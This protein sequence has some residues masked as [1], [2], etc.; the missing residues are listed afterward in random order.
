MTIKDANTGKAFDLSEMQS[1][2]DDIS[3]ALKK[4]SLSPPLT[5]SPEL[6]N[7]PRLGSLES[8][9]PSIEEQIR[10]SMDSDISNY[11]SQ[12]SS[13]VSNVDTAAST[14]PSARGK[15][16]SPTELV[17]D[18]VPTRL[19]YDRGNHLVGTNFDFAIVPENSS[20]SDT[21]HST[22]GSDE[23]QGV[24]LT[25][26][27]WMEQS[28]ST[29]P[30][31]EANAS[32]VEKPLTAPEINISDGTNAE[33]MLAAAEVLGSNQVAKES[34]RGK[35]LRR[36]ARGIKVATTHRKII[37][38]R[39]NAA[40]VGVR[41][42]VE[43]EITTLLNIISK[44]RRDNDALALQSNKNYIEWQQLDN[45]LKDYNYSLEHEDP[46]TVAEANN[47]MKQLQDKYQLLEETNKQQTMTL[48][49]EFDDYVHS[50]QGEVDAVQTRLH[51]AQEEIT[52][53]E[54]CKDDYKQQ[55]DNALSRQ[56]LNL[57]DQQ[58]ISAFQS[59]EMILIQDKENMSQLLEGETRKLQEVELAVA[60]LRLSRRD[61]ERKLEDAQD[62]ITRLISANELLEARAEPIDFLGLPSEQ[63]YEM[64]QKDQKL[65]EMTDELR[66]ANETIADIANANGDDTTAALMDSH[67]HKVNM[68][69]L[70][71]QT[72][73]HEISELQQKLSDQRNSHE[74]DQYYAVHMEEDMQELQI[75][76]NAVSKDLRA[77]REQ[78]ANGNHTLADPKSWQ[79]MNE[80]SE[81]REQAILLQKKAEEQLEGFKELQ[82]EFQDHV[83]Q[84][85]R[86]I[87]GFEE[88]KDPS[89]C[90][91]YL[92]DD[93][94]E[95]AARTL[96][97]FNVD[98]SGTNA[99]GQTEAVEEE[100]RKF[101]CYR[102]PHCTPANWLPD[103]QI[104]AA[105]GKP[106][107]EWAMSP[108][109]QEHLNK[110]SYYSDK[111][112]E[113]IICLW[114]HIWEFEDIVTREEC[115]ERV[116]KSRKSLVK[117]TEELIE[118]EVNTI[119]PE[120]EALMKGYAHGPL[121]TPDHWMPESD[122]GF[123]E[124][125]EEEEEEEKKSDDVKNDGD[126]DSLSNHYPADDPGNC[127]GN[128]NGHQ[129]TYASI[130]SGITPEKPSQEAAEHLEP[131]DASTTNPQSNST[132]MT[133]TAS[134]V[135]LHHSNTSN[136]VTVA[137][138]SNTPLSELDA[139]AE[140]M[141]ENYANPQ[142]VIN[143]R[144]LAQHLAAHPELLD[145]NE[146]IPS[147]SPH[148]F[149]HIDPSS[150][151]NKA[152]QM[153][154]H[155]SWGSGED[156]SFCQFDLEEVDLDAMIRELEE[157]NVC[158]SASEQTETVSGK[159]KDDGDGA[160]KRVRW[161]D[162]VAAAGLVGMDVGL[163][164]V[165]Y[166]RMVD[167]CVGLEGNEKVEGEK[168]KEKQ[169]NELKKERKNR[170]V[171]L[172]KKQKQEPEKRERRGIR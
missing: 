158:E 11:T 71:I 24:E 43:L 30:D 40:A 26:A 146:Q 63:R 151:K 28:D 65:D 9:N 38:C 82:V 129:P 3:E 92:T 74:R 17:D 118:F 105:A 95:L 16:H 18:V 157:T 162:D 55:L 111:R 66:C 48:H 169:K 104:Q 90:P 81:G 168:P 62:K 41:E 73:N 93:R 145:N 117:E 163:E 99:R 141:A 19:F 132:A 170:N 45:R 67:A 78:L 152:K 20:P 29:M 27:T 148:V 47:V 6:L 34:H 98:V 159:E 91:I 128:I 112:Q 1:S 44:L 114:G 107:P 113:L 166:F 36:R 68:L 42:D 59:K 75:Q 35:K 131:L 49:R 101:G 50:H 115:D 2:E 144:L 155:S 121:H 72:N 137:S 13:S 57:R 125:E 5:F 83:C 10:Q 96:K 33:A 94:D 116:W 14:P 156:I 122:D 85:W 120:S 154:T 126:G 22:D 136:P 165:R 77:L 149:E 167:R 130:N 60:E 70:M 8:I 12:A 58:I 124:E 172:S 171:K 51:R 52:Y 86:R 84:M 56:G 150:K 109:V 53:A 4:H 142:Q 134:I 39:I 64:A 143:D 54:Q 80:C 21:Q 108:A 160:E 123:E 23:V 25:D 61:A 103:A 164:Q 139:W 79:H 76:Y 100:I 161:A 102:G 87:C 119:Y 69:T 110:L 138:G 89:E 97:L 140:I 88:L 133:T 135:S 15:K 127:E 46:D 31:G 153:S 32:D 147:V 7:E 106:G 37:Q